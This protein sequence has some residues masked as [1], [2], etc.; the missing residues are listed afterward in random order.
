MNH[1]LQCPFGKSAIENILERTLLWGKLELEKQ[2]T[3]TE[4]WLAFGKT[5]DP[6][7]HHHETGLGTTTVKSVDPN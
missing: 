1:K 2:Y 7:S 3:G 4:A 6:V 5:G